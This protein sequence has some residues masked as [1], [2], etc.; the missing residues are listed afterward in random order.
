MLLVVQLAA[1]M[2]FPVATFFVRGDAERLATA[3]L[4]FPVE[5]YLSVRLDMERL[6]VGANAD[7]SAAAFQARY[8]AATQQLEARLTSEPSVINVVFAE[9][10]PRQYH[11]NNQIEVDEGAVAPHDERGHLVGSSRVD[12]KYMNVLGVSTLAGRWFNSSEANPDARVAVVNTF[13][14]D[15]VM[16][17]KN[18]IGRRVRYVR[19]SRPDTQPWFEIVGVAPDVGIRSGWGPAGI[20]HPLV[21]ASLYPVSAAIHVRGDP[22]VFAARLRAIATDVDVTMR[23]T[24]L[25]PL[26]DVVNAEVNAQRFWVRITT[27]V[28]VMVLVFSLVSTY[29][30]MSFAVSRRTREIGVRVALGGTPWRIVTAVFAHP[31]RQLSMGLLAGTLL[32][33]ALQGGTDNGVPTVKQLLTLGAYTTLMT[34]V[35][36]I[37]CAVPTLRAL[38]VQP[39]EALRDY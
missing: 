34:I 25:M 6:P 22:K 11:P 16:G 20:Y 27:I 13:F 17:G 12:P 30:V 9:Y 24:D 15:S 4:P 1:T 10:L 32:V 26:K 35:Y 2:G 29:A 33:W 5:E 23:L 37:A 31:L 14:V 19:G 18:P 21:R 28:S 7:T 3:P 36:L 38:S 8:L 39:T